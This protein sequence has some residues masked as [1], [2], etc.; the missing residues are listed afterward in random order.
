[1]LTTSPG[2]RV[3]QARLAD[4]RA[5]G[6]RQHVQVAGVAAALGD[7]R[8]CAAAAA[9]VSRPR[10]CRGRDGRVERRRAER[11]SGR[12][13]WR[14]RPSGPRRQVRP[15]SPRPRRSAEPA[16]AARRRRHQRLEACP[17][18][19]QQPVEAAVSRSRARSIISWTAASP[20]TRVHQLLVEERGRRRDAHL[21]AG[22]AAGVR[23]HAE[24]DGHGARVDAQRRPRATPRLVGARTR[25]RPPRSS[26]PSRPARPASAPRGRATWSTGPGAAAMSRAPWGPRPSGSPC[27]APPPTRAPRRAP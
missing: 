17:L 13:S 11:R 10:S 16:S 3:E 15:P 19:G 14:L 2:D 26:A 27:G 7:G 8:L 5:A 9:V 22:D 18:V 21:C 20:N 24:H 4:T 1:M 23:E 25:P 6:E 12:R